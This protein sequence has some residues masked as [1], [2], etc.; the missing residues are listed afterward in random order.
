ML[1][2]IAAALALTVCL[3]GCA[4][5][6]PPADETAAANPAAANPAAAAD[7]AAAPAAAP[8]P[9]PAPAP[10]DHPGTPEGAR[11]LLAAFTAPGANTTALSAALRPTAADYAA[12]F[13]AD[14][15][16]KA[17]QTYA[18]AWDA[19]QMHIA[20]KEGQTEVQ[21]NSATTDQIKAGDPAAQEFPGGYAEIGAQLQPGV[22][23]YRFKFV[24]PGK[25]LGMA[26]D[27]LAH[28]NG[29]WVIFPKP[30]RALR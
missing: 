12:V 19:G 26:F 7:P 13:T 8:A 21:L 6:A 23:L 22:T 2:R 15:A 4:R 29:R 18:P 24:E 5:K 16:T 11:A 30:W 3:F 10:I 1:H 14:A 20:P 28:V 25:D 27:G 17:E 9:A